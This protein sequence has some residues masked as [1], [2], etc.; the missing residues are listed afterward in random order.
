MYILYTYILMYNIVLCIILLDI[1]F[2][3][4]NV[5]TIKL[6]QVYLRGRERIGIII[7]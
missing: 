3:N 1:L 4:F 5:Y 7:C 2:Y 6:P